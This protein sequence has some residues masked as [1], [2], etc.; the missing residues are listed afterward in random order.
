MIQSILTT[1]PM[2]VCAILTALL[3]LSLYRDKDGPR[4]RLL[5]FMIVATLL[6]TAHCI[7]FNGLK[8]TIPF[9]DTVYCFC[10]P[11]VYPLYYIYIE[12]LTQRHPDRRRQALLLVPAVLCSLTVGAFYLLMSGE[13]T[14]TFISHYLYHDEYTTLSGLAWWQGVAHLMVKIVFALEIPPILILGW[15][16]ITHYN[17]IVEQNYSDPD[18]K[19]LSPIKPLLVLFVVTSLVSFACNVIGRYRFTDSLW[20][21][22]VPSVTFSLLILLIGHIGLQQRFHIRNMDENAEELSPAIAQPQS[23]GQN[24]LREGLRQLMET[25]HIYLQPNLK[26]EDL[27]RRLNTNR[28]YVYN[29]I[30]VENGVSFSEFINRRRIEHAARLIAQ[31]PKVLLADVA[32][33]SGFS[34]PS[35]FYRNF[36]QFMGC[37]PSEYAGAQESG[38]ARISCAGPAAT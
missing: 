4:I 9:S 3:A 23:E 37:T 1:L 38:G 19:T 31:N 15:R 35:A 33:M 34:S 28:A 18:D 8:Q 29:V 11:A 13:E 17:L 10:N 6:Y 30:N 2:L 24:R 25:E 26:L 36:K 21:L 7:Y 32:T 14:A 20:L 22:A 16:H 12:E 27:A 5:V